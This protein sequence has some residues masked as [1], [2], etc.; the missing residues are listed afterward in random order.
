MSNTTETRNLAQII[1]VRLKLAREAIGMTLADAA[2][3]MGF[4]NYQVLISIEK[5]ERSVKACELVEFAHAYERSLNFFLSAVEPMPRPAVA[6]RG[7]GDDA[8]AKPVEQRFLRYCEDYARLETLAE[9]EPTRFHLERGTKMNSYDDAVELGEALNKELELG[10]HPAHGLCPALEECGVKI[11]AGDIGSAGS[12]ASTRGDFGAGILINWSNAPWRINYDISHEL[13]HLLTWTQFPPESQLVPAGDK[14]LA[15]KF[16]DAFASAFLL[17]ESVVVK[18]HRSRTKTGELTDVDRINMAL[19]FGV[20]SAALIWRLVNLGLMSQD[21]GKK[22]IESESL[23]EADKTARRGEWRK[24]IAWPTPRFVAVAFKCL[25][26]GRL[27]RARF[28]QLMDIRRGQINTF[29]AERGYDASEDYASE[30][31]TA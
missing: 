7:R 9:G 20:S 16:A 19:D 23:R 24:P 4:D 28:A 3:R 27:S 25:L 10:S 1:A 15:D 12:A 5:G 6:W 22:A 17:P 30:T 31:G 26:L 11:M 8:L 18:E 14:S 13:F 21:A 2:R 29:L